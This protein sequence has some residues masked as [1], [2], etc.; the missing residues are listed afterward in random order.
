MHIVTKLMFKDESNIANEQ[1]YKEC[2]SL[3]NQR[4]LQRIY[5]EVYN[6]L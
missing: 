5:I 1:I 2:F 3:L 4:D 6:K